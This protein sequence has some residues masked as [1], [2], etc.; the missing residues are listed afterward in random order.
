MTDTKQIN[1]E[2]AQRTAR[3]IAGTVLG[4]NHIAGKHWQLQVLCNNGRYDI[5][6]W[7]DRK[8]QHDYA[9]ALKP[10]DV[11]SLQVHN[12]EHPGCNPW[13]VFDYLTFDPAARALCT[14]LERKLQEQLHA[15]KT[16]QTEYNLTLQHLKTQQRNLD[17]QLAQRQTFDFWRHLGGIAGSI[18]AIAAAPATGGASLAALPGCG[19]MLCPSGADLQHQTGQQSLDFSRA[20][21]DNNL[22][23]TRSMARTAI[24]IVD[25][26]EVVITNA[27]RL[28]WKTATNGNSYGLLPVSV[29]SDLIAA[30]S[31][32]TPT[33]VE[34]AERQA[35]ILALTTNLSNALTAMHCAQFLV[36]L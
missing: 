32:A 25:Q 19:V 27:K 3:L 12:Y 35:E 26:L 2:R 28:P 10:G 22:G 8:V 34:A 4:L 33:A 24:D 31:T 11:V 23:I 36:H 17:D 30:A 7:N 5:S 18:A 13:K 29:R 1:I 6:V 9:M 20:L 15:I 21:A 14:A 16:R